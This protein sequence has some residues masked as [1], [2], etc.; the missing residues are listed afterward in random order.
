MSDWKTLPRP[1]MSDGKKLDPNTL[2][3]GRYGTEEMVNIWWPDQTFAYSLKAQA[4]AIATLGALRP[5]LVSE[6][7]VNEVNSKANL[8]AIDPNRIRELED[9]T[10]HDIIAVNMALEEVISNEA[11]SFVNM[12]RTSADT[13]QTAKALQL[14]AALEVIA[15]SVENLRDILL[16][17]SMEWKDIPAMDTT[18]LYD[19]L[20]TTAGRPLAHYA[21]MLQSGLD[22][23]KYIYENSLI[24][25]WGDATGNHH[26]AEVLWLDGMKLQEAYC[27]MLGLKHMTASA[28]TSWLEYEADVMFVLTRISET[29]NNIAKC[30]ATGRGDD[31]NIFINTD[32][33][34]KKWSTAM[35]HKDS[36]NGNPTT[37]E[38]VMSMR[39]YMNGNL[40]TSMMNSE[41]PYARNL[42]GSSNMRINREDGFKFMDHCVRSLARTVYNL[43]LKEEISK[44]RVLRSFG[45]VTSA[46][47]MTYITDHTKVENPLWRSEAHDLTA[48]LATK[49]YNAWKQYYD[50]V[51]E[52]ERILALIPNKET[53]KL[54]TDPLVYIGQS[55]QI[56]EK[57]FADYYQRKTIES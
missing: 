39:N 17:K 27:Q 35:P 54:L 14:K 36:K 44:N 50:V 33:K 5:D 30:V 6:Q 40:V 56:I 16:D 15:T 47:L 4:A 9:K 19:A 57:V 28:Q 29:M 45:T 8:E 20:P 46:Q 53:L 10:G 55:K 48:E 24:G 22:R 13:T 11:K 21:E 38:Q 1:R 3:A 12:A 25:K 18:H 37:E 23:L 26:A 52:D 41:F 2:T 34:K 42:S 7:I 31:M 43:W 32:A 51:A 49:A